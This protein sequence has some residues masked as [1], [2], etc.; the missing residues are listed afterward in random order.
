M[1][2]FKYLFNMFPRIS[3]LF[4]ILIYYHVCLLAITSKVLSCSSVKAIVVLLFGVNKVKMARKPVKK[5][6]ENAI[7]CTGEGKRC[8]G[9]KRRIQR[10]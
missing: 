8:K 10:R 2:N 3:I 4:L 1:L 7:G 9:N 6:K 5:Q